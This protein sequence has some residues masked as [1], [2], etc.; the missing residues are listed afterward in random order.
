NGFEQYRTQ[1][2]RPQNLDA[3][4]HPNRSLSIRHP[5]HLSR[6]RSGRPRRGAAQRGLTLRFNR[7]V[8]KDISI[9]GVVLALFEWEASPDVDA[10]SCTSNINIPTGLSFSDPIVVLAA[11]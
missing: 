1:Q 2:V 3:H 9:D 5:V 8:L 7:V 11:A 4:R 6:R 10:G